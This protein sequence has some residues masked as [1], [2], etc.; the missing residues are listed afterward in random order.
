MFNSTTEICLRW[1]CV[2]LARCLLPSEDKDWLWHAVI[3][4]CEALSRDVGRKE[5]PGGGGD[6][7]SAAWPVHSA[8]CQAVL[9]VS[10]QVQSVLW[11]RSCCVPPLFTC[12]SFL[13][14]R[15]GAELGKSVVYQETNGGK[16][17]LCCLQ[18]F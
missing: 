15:L 16:R 3:N 5:A 7:T 11:L 14:R 12:H 1:H 10:W 18:V 4:C 9:V 8:P 2:G 17:T 13:S 6:C